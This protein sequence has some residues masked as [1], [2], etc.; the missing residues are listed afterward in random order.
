MQSSSS[1]EAN[2][3]ILD[4]AKLKEMCGELCGN[5]DVLDDKVTNVL[6]AMVD[7]MVENLVD[8]SCMYANH[9]DSDTLEKEDV[10]FAVSR[11]FPEISRDH[12]VRDVELA[13]AQ[14]VN[15]NHPNVN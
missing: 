6:A 12:K 9:R 4:K 8:Y 11:L 14:Q 3:N 1:K 2:P 5:R 13:I 15:A 7:Q 10:Q